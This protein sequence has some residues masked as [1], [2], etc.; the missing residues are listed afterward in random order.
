MASTGRP[1]C[2][3]A[4]AARCPPVTL[5]P[6]SITSR[7]CGT[8]SQYVLTEP[9]LSE[10]IRPTGSAAAGVGGAGAAGPALPVPVHAVA[11]ATPI[12]TLSSR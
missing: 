8:G 6:V 12:S 11:T 3:I 2:L 7:P 4:A 9:G 1:V 10:A 5:R